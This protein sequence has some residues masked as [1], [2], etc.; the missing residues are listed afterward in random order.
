MGGVNHNG[1][2]TGLDECLCTFQRVVGNTHARSHAQ[3][4][5]LVF[6]GHGLVFRLGNIFIGDES[7]QSALL[8][9]HRQFLNL[10]LLQNLCSSSQV[11]LLVSGH[12]VLAGHHLVYFLV[13]PAFE[14]QVAVGDDAHQFSILVNHGNTANVV[15]AHHVQCILHGGA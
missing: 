10:V 9:H 3:S 11:G 8:I 2:G 12:Q 7:H 15:V 5:F 13:E 14:A 4:A 1:I 6:A